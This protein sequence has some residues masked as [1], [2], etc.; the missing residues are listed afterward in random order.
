MANSAHIWRIELSD[1]CPMILQRF[2]GPRHT[3]NDYSFV[4]IE[5]VDHLHSMGFAILPTKFSLNTTQ[6]SKRLPI[7]NGAIGQRAGMIFH[8]FLSS[9]HIGHYSLAQAGIRMQR[10]TTLYFAPYEQHFFCPLISLMQRLSR[11]I[12]HYDR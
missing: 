2:I 7:H 8:Y 11:G 3:P 1:L 10:V 6:I 12:P 9:T 5:L 4:S